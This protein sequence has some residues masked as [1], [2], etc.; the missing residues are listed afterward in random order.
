MDTTQILVKKRDGTE[1]PFSEEKVLRSMRRVD[2]SEELQPQVLSHIQ[3]K[4]HPGITTEEIFSHIL[5]Y[6]KEKDKSSSVK[7]NLK[8]AIFD[9]GPTGFP[10]EKYMERIFKEM[11]YKTQIDLIMQ[12]ECVTHE[13]DVLLEDGYGKAIVESKFHNQLGTKTEVQVALYVYARFLDVSKNNPD[14]TGVWIVTNTKLSVDAMKFAQ[15]KRVR[16]IAWNFPAQGNLQ[17]F[18]ENPKMYPIT[19]LDGLT[20]QEKQA[21]LENDIVL[22]SDFAQVSDGELA[23]KYMI[24]KHHIEEAKKSAGLL[25][26][27][28]A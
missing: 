12:G 11:G 16:V 7:F 25:L 15:C 17:D 27:T 18:V 1:E 9:L 19:I 23:T 2:L 10:F 6:L 4:L 5:E 8:R 26:G 21:L 3:Q 28:V 20:T 24:N 13:I 22:C 14:I